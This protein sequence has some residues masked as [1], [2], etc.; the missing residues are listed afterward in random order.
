MKLL[1]QVRDKIRKKHYSV[2]TE[3]AYVEWIRRFIIFHGKRRL[4]DMGEKEISQYLSHL[5]SELKVATS[6]RNQPLST[7]PHKWCP[8]PGCH[9]RE[10]GHP[11]FSSGF[12]P[13]ACGNDVLR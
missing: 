5:A 12:P 2:R 11:G 3:Q 10:G 1:D 9:A 4:K 6:T 7:T 8:I 13:R